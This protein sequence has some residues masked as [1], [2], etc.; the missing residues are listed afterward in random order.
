MTADNTT[1]PST[2]ETESAADITTDSA[3]DDAVDAGF[4]A[5]D[6]LEDVPDDTDYTL[7]DGD[8]GALTLAQ[9][10]CL[11]R[12]LK[13]YTITAVQ[14]PR[15]WAVLLADRGVLKSRLNDL[16]LDLHIDVDRGVA[17][18]VQVRSDA[19]GVFPPLLKDVAYTKEETALLVYLR[20]KQLAERTDGG[21][22]VVVERDECLE[23]IALYRPH[24]AANPAAD[25]DRAER[26]LEA[27]VRIGAL[28]KTSDPERYTIATVVETL[29][30]LERLRA[31]LEWFRA[32]NSPA[33]TFTHARIELDDPDE[34]ADDVD[35]DAA[36]DDEEQ[37]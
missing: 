33:A 28:V 21:H 16:F 12:L 26:A 19:P 5:P 27:A 23:Q 25:R 15:D 17:Y 29:L 4:F 9:R 37:A 7:F 13:N 2:V 35:D 11:V 8:D 30:P 20:Q 22:R 6:P 1:E 18:K 10:Q 36:P 14:D 31:L 24:G 32:Q 34:H 3:A